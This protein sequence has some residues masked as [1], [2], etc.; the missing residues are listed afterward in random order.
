MTVQD[1]ANALEEIAPQPYAESF[2]NVG[3]LIGNSKQTVS[4]A[5]LTLDCTE[6]VVE[7]AIQK[8]ANLIITFH[9]IIFKGLKRITGK[10]YVERV[11]LKAIKHD[12]S[13]Y[14]IHTNLDFAWQGS[15][16]KLCDI[17]DL[18]DIKILIPKEN[19]I[20]KLTF[21]VPIDSTEKVR[22]ALFSIG[23]GSIGN[24]D[25][26][27]FNIEGMGSFKGNKESNP[28]LGKKEMLHFEKETAVNMTFP[29]YLE[30]RIV[31]TLKKVHP[32]EEV[33]YEI[34]SLDNINQHIGIGM[35]GNL[36]KPMDEHEFLAFVKEKLPTDCIRHSKLTG[37]T[38][39]KI[40]VLGGS[41]SFGL[42]QAKRVEADAY[43][44]GDFKYHEFF[45]SENQI[46]ICDI[47]HYESEQ[48]IKSL[49]YDVLTKKFTNFA[50]ALSEVNT[51]P[52]NYY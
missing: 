50:F 14:A 37:K 27:S 42:E 18:S 3:L 13:I 43:I 44:S 20:K 29:W 16:K 47:G 23:A 24:Y 32:Y 11:V 1:I 49:L 33:A 4:K 25:H 21:Y 22:D 40:A 46:L 17:L 6:E 7:E 48:F 41:G 12:I 38:I 45:S 30:H 9:P 19:T 15:N 39:Q 31:S 36:P 10:N 35:Y 52:V 2:D 26:C 5:L 34:T 51:N 28:T 8:K